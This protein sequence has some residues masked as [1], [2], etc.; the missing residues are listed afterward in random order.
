MLEG[1]AP[2]FADDALS[3]MSARTASDRAGF[4]LRTL[5]PGMR[6][7]DAGCGPGSITRGFVP[8]V[9][10]GRV[11]GVDTEPRQFPAE[12][13]VDFVAGSVYALPVPSESIDLAFAHALFEHLNR[14]AEALLELRRVLRPGGVLA[15][16]TS[17][18]SRARLQPKTVNVVAALR[19]H[20][21]LRRRA[22]GDPFAGKHLAG[23]VREAGF[24]EV[25]THA[26]FR[27]DMPYRD[28]ARYVES[29][30]D[31]ALSASPADRD[32]LAS[33]ARSAWAWSHGGDGSF[34]QCWVELVAVK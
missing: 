21:L 32:Q 24:R 15:L 17:D 28:L 18:W 29:R 30:L 5:E 3:M 16:S 12:S 33:A 27:P 25:R 20:H 31:A 22:G 7:L 10:A 26:R 6:V 9:G 34:H 1:Y 13:T 14:P 23:S 11:L 4:V 8:I 19:G 2:G